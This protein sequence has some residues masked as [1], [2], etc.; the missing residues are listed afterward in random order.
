MAANKI[1]VKKDNKLNKLVY[2]KLNKKSLYKWYDQF[3][4]YTLENWTIT[5]EELCYQEMPQMLM[6]VEAL[7]CK[8]L[9][10]LAM[11]MVF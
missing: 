6:L 8:Y 2:Q 9:H 11:N 7:V 3:F 4:L 5:N 10:V 1:Y